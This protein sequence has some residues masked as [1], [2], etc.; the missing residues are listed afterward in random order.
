MVLRAY[1]RA[2][3]PEVSY[4]CAKTTYYALLE[5]I[6]LEVFIELIVHC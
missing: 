5:W 4:V 1:I 6:W 2:K 3:Y